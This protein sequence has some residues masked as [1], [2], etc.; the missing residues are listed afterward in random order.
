VRRRRFVLRIIFDLGMGRSQRSRLKWERERKMGLTRRAPDTS[1]RSRRI[2]IRFGDAIIFPSGN[3]S[4]VPPFVKLCFCVTLLL[5][6][7]H[8]RLRSFHE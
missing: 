3:L 6:G 7:V 5:V 4:F 1:C 8:K 2:S